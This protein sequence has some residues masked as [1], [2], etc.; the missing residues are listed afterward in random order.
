LALERRYALSASVG[1]VSAL[2]DS[3]R[4]LAAEK[5]RPSAALH[6]DGIGGR[7][8]APPIV[9]SRD[10]S[11]AEALVRFEPLDSRKRSAVRGSLSARKRAWPMPVQMRVQ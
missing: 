2:N 6:Q 1:N 4:R 11:V 3:Y 10:H 9:V 8:I 5:A 7:G